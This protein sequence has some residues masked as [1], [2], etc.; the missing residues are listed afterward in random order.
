MPSSLEI[1][2]TRYA[3]PGLRRVGG[4]APARHAGARPLTPRCLTPPAPPAA[5]AGAS[6]R[7]R[8]CRRRCASTA[9]R[10]YRSPHRSPHPRPRRRRRRAAAAGAP[11]RVRARERPRGAPSRGADSTPPPAV[12]RDRGATS[13]T[14]TSSSRSA[15]SSTSAARSGPRKWPPQCVRRGRRD[16]LG[17]I[18]LGDRRRAQCAR[19]TSPSADE[20]TRS[21]RARVDASTAAACCANRGKRVGA[22]RHVVDGRP[23]L[24]ERSAGRRRRPVHRGDGR[25]A[26][27][28]PVGR[29]PTSVGTHSPGD[30]SVRRFPAAK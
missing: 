23:S 25:R 13:R 30:S 18:H 28:R 7:A 6:C 12:A 8:A 15:A 3:A 17:D 27:A 26:D 19:T 9:S 1:S 16:H 21:A 29:P 10:W 5:P 14:A 24:T 11:T 20:P 4:R 2:Q 22:R